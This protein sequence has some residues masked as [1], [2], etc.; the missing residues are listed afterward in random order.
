MALLAPQVESPVVPTAAP[1]RGRCAGSVGESGGATVVVTADARVSLLAASMSV[2]PVEAP[3]GSTSVGLFRTAVLEA[4]S[5]PYWREE[6]G[7]VPLDG[8]ARTTVVFDRPS[9]AEAAALVVPF[10]PVV[11][12]NATPPRAVAAPATSAGTE[13]AATNRRRV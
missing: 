3:M 8:A 2:I 12:R 11:A 6:H 5:G 13:I 4:G 9:R 1:T 10:D 7:K